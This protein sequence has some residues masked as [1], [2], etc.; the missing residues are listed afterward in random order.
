[1]KIEGPWTRV[2]KV[3]TMFQRNL[4]LNKFFY[5]SAIHTALLMLDEKNCCFGDLG[6]QK[7]PIQESSYCRSA[8]WIFARSCRAGLMNHC[9]GK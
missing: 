1:M 8:I 9:Q 6:S 5:I 4:L 2:L 7:Y 3:M